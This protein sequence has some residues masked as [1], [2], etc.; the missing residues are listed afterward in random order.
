[1]SLSERTNVLIADDKE[2]IRAD[3]STAIREVLPGLTIH[4][5]ENPETIISMIRELGDRVLLVV[6][7]GKMVQY[8]DGELVVRAA[9]EAEV[10]H[11]AYYSATA[12]F[13]K[14]LFPNT[15]ALIDKPLHDDVKGGLKRWLTSI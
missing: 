3:V 15:V 2:A 13:N 9:L 10:P 14:G 7:D 11:I 6:T 5:F 4:E 8:G 1:M 12:K